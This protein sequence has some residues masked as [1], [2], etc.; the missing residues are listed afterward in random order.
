MKKNLI[1]LIFF[2]TISEVSFFS[3]Q[4]WLKSYA[5]GSETVFTSFS[6]TSEGGSIVTGYSQVSTSPTVIEGSVENTNM[7]IA[8]LNY[9]GEIEWQK[10]YGENGSEYGY[11]VIESTAGG[12]L[13]VGET[14]SFGA[15]SNDAF[16]VRVDESGAVLWA[17][18][19]GGSSEDWAVDVKETD[20][21]DYIVLGVT[22]VGRS[23]NTTEN[24]DIFLVGIDDYGNILWQKFYSGA[25]DDVAYNLLKTNEGDFLITGATSS[26]EM[27]DY[28]AL[29]IKTD[30]GG[31]VKW[32]KL[33]GTSNNDF[34]YYLTKAK[35]GGFLLVGETF[36]KDK[37]NRV[38]FSNAYIVRLNSS[39][40]DE[41]Q[42]SYGFAKNNFAYSAKPFGRHGFVIGG[43]SKEA[44]G[45]FVSWTFKIDWS[46][47]IIW[48]TG[49]DFSGNE[50]LYCSKPQKNRSVS[51]LGVVNSGESVYSFFGKG[52]K[53]GK[54]GSCSY[55]TDCPITRQKG[56]FGSGIIA[57]STTSGT[58]TCKGIKKSVKANQGD[59]SEETLCE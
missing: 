42:K 19:I 55:V 9:N 33:F 29:V 58:L 17:K 14:T 46:G 23:E 8:K 2:F 36:L 1:F 27:G 57:L 5:G 51:I 6:F 11:S 59:I 52:D 10:T 38:G 4:I 16:V 44:T 41:W 43:V 40:G 22:K 20:K 26:K 45:N 47:K 28:D 39:G 12:Y 21:G 34:G 48:K 3:Q 15:S 7:L 54:F 13:A 37:K 53:E 56:F 32:Q 24:Y 49:Y 25:G 50:V 18:C 30:A 31:V 35:E